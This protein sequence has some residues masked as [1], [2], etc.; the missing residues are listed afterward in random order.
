MDDR[1]NKQNAII[2]NSSGGGIAM[3]LDFHYYKG[4]GERE[5]Q[6][7]EYVLVLNDQCGSVMSVSDKPNTLRSQMKHHEPVVCYG[8]SPYTSHAMLSSNPHSGIYEAKTSRTLDL[9]CCNPACNQGGIVVLTFSGQHLGID[10]CKSFSHFA[11]RNDTHSIG[12][13]CYEVLHDRESS[14]GQQSQDT[15]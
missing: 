11:S 10:S 14:T 12:S 9:N 15:K 5:G 1:V 8:I 7:R 4:Q 2:I 6:E 3:T 13:V